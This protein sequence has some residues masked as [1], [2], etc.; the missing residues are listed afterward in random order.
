MD[1]SA[2]ETRQL[3]QLEL[4]LLQTDTRRSAERLSTLLAEEFVEYGASGKRYDKPQTIKALAESPSSDQT[5]LRQFTAR[6]LAK[7][8][9]L[10][11]YQSEKQVPDGDNQLA[12]RSSIWR[13]TR[14]GWRILFHQATPSR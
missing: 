11:T 6:R 12:L 9:A 10:V 4:E 2:E 13:Q 7:N 1:L 3:R 14:N 5:T 8:L